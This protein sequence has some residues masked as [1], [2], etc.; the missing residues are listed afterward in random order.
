MAQFSPRYGRGSPA[1][2]PIRSRLRQGCEIFTPL[3]PVLLRSWLPPVRGARARDE[4]H[5][6]RTAESPCGR[7]FGKL[8]SND[9]IDIDDIDWHILPAK[10]FTARNRRSPAIRRATLVVLR[11]AFE[12]A[13]VELIDG[14]GGDPGVRLRK[15]YR[16]KQSK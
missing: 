10:A 3:P 4:W 14:N 2:A 6:L 13:G 16:L 1:T 15:R 11:Q 12:R 8:S 5:R 7:R 9:L